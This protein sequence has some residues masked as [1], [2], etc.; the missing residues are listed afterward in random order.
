MN[1]YKKNVFNDVFR[2]LKREI[3]GLMLKVE[4]LGVSP[5]KRQRGRAFRCNLFSYLKKDLRYNHSRKLIP[6]GNLHFEY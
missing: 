1:G 3:C 4:G 5:Q 6:I 2:W